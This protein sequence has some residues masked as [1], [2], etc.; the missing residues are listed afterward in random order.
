MA[1]TETPNGASVASSSGNWHEQTDMDHLDK[2]NLDFSLNKGGFHDQ[3]DNIR[4]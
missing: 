2:N 1:E 3:V 4:K